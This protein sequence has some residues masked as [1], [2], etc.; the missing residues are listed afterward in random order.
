MSLKRILRPTNTR[1]RLGVGLVLA[2]LFCIQCTRSD[3]LRGSS[4]VTAVSG[5]T[6]GQN[7]PQQVRELERLAAEDHVALLQRALAHYRDSFQD[8]TCTLIKQERING[9]LRPEQ[10]IEVKYVDRPFSVSM[11]WVKNAPLGDRVLYVEGRHNGRMLVQPKGLL[12]KLVGT[13]LRVP[14]G[15]EV[16]ANTL[17][18]VTMFGFRR[19]MESLLRVYT[20]AAT[21]GDNEIRF[22]GYKEVAGRRALVLERRLP[23][24][25]D[26]PAKTTIW[27]L[28]AEH[29][30]PMGLKGY[31]WEDELICSYVYKDVK[32]NVGLKPTDFVPEANGMKLKK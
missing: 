29:L 23:F 4:F 16:M 10:W 28:D 30:V 14:D 27:Y 20:L 26:Y 9:Q 6:I 2:G 1:I 5:Q 12:G 32:L 21:R 15:P 19:S 25:K 3:A 17:R 18:P 13:V 7:T 31:G 8:Y 11:H 22:G 24:R